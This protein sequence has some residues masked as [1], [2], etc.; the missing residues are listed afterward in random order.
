M[1]RKRLGWTLALCLAA[2]GALAAGNDDIARGLSAVN[3]GDNSQAI[4]F[5]SS[6]LASGN[7]E[8][9]LAQIAYFDRARA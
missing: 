3:R 8:P 1:G 2:S 4:V 7:L 5:F 9:G 6:A